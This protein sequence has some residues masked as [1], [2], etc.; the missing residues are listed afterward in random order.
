MKLKNLF[1]VGIA[2]VLGLGLAASVQA[3]GDPAKGKALYPT[4]AGCHGMNG[5]GNQAL[6]AP[7]IA[8]QQE[9]YVARQLRYYQEGIRGAH[10][11]DVYGMQMRPMSMTVMGE[12]ADH[13]AAY[14]ASLP[15]TSHAPTMGGD[16]NAG[17][18]NYAVCMSCHGMNGEGNDALNAPRLAGQYDWYTYRQLMNWKTG[19]RGTHAK[20]TYGAQMIGMVAT[21][22]NEDAVKN[23]AA[24]IATLK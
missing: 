13:V 22:P 7:A 1:A 10:P 12:N 2:A 24:Y 16:P 20:D 17:K 11:K 18:A 3:A 21:L 9:W 15:K 4:C 8:G 14:I 19:V 5:E 23:V 6:N